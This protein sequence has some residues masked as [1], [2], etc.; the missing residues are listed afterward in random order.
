[1]KG[2]EKEKSVCVTSFNQLMLILTSR[3]TQTVKEETHQESGTA[4]GQSIPRVSGAASHGDFQDSARRFKP[5]L[6]F[7]LMLG[8]LYLI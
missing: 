2:R 5:W 7:D 4:L 1:M 8:R 6:F 3:R